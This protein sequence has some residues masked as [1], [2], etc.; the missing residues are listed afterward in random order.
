MCAE[1][2]AW[3]LAWG[4]GGE[5]IRHISVWYGIKVGVNI[6][7]FYSFRYKPR[8]SHFLANGIE[9]FRFTLII[10]MQGEKSANPLGC[11]IDYLS[12]GCFEIV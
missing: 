7:P 9:K 8:N 10:Q 2:V 5:S 3:V 4:G 12:A 1:E 6:L 11:C